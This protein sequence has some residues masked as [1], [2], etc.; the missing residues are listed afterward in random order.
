MCQA[1][2]LCS[3]HAFSQPPSNPVTQG[4]A[5]SQ[6]PAAPALHMGASAFSGFVGGRHTMNTVTGS[7][8][9][10]THKTDLVF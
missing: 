5:A 9:I 1:S 2:A 6:S 3:P 7:T 4:E 10:L 8:L